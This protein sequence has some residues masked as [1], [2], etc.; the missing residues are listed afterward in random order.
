MRHRIPIKV[1]TRENAFLEENTIELA[2]I[3][4]CVSGEDAYNKYLKDVRC[5]II[6]NRSYTVEYV[7]A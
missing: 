6:D 4:K 5:E 1:L 2:N 7:N 3:L